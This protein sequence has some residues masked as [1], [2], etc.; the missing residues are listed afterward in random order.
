MNSRYSKWYV[1]GVLDEHQKLI[2]IGKGSGARLFTSIMERG[3]VS[4]HPMAFF[5]TEGDALA[6]E[7]DW[8][9]DRKPSHNRYV[10]RQPL[11][12][13]EWV[14]EAKHDPREFARR[15][16]VWIDAAIDSGL[17]G[18]DQY[19]FKALARYRLKQRLA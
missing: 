3:G 19:A 4:A 7:R 16:F 17:K 15:A 9:R 1:Y 12:M 10:P 2:Y 18:K 13:S 6:F 5:L 14:G 11:T 8:I